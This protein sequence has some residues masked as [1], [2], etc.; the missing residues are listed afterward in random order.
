MEGAGEGT[1]PGLKPSSQASVLS[2]GQRCLCLQA[3]GAMP[4]FADPRGSVP[5]ASRQGGAGGHRH[6]PGVAQM[7]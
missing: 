7:E 6:L 1:H 2:T 5:A 4:G 3:H